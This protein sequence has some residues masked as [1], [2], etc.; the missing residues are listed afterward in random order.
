M[1]ASWQGNTVWCVCVFLMAG[2]EESGSLTHELNTDTCHL[3]PQTQWCW[4]GQ[5]F[6]QR[7][8]LM[9]A[10]TTLQQLTFILT[11]DRAE[12]CT[13]PS[14][15]KSQG[16]GAKSQGGKLTVFCCQLPAAVV[17]IW[18]LAGWPVPSSSHPEGTPAPVWW[19]KQLSHRSHVERL[20]GGGKILKSPKYYIVVYLRHITTLMKAEC[21][22]RI[23]Y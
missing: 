5:R 14:Q 12:S 2:E 4:K 10:A 19:S 23:F 15:K 1:C 21:I 9:P 6:S 16:G 7:W 8:S 17:R 20:C 3:R 13:N 22:T 18:R 11:P